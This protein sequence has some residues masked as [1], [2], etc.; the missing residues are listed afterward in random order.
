MPQTSS[1]SNIA[2][3]VR[4]LGKKYTLGGS[5]EK[6]LTIRYAI[7]NFV[8]VPFVYFADMEHAIE[9]GIFQ[10]SDINAR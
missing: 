5:Q 4:N 9:T 10:A 3:R 6:Y 1:E 8:K 2:I 7:V